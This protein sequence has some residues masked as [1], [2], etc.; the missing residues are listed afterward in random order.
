MF[1]LFNGDFIMAE[2][3]YFYLE[4][5]KELYQ[6]IGERIVIVDNDKLLQ[7][8]PPN[9]KIKRPPRTSLGGLRPDIT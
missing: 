4:S 3:R 6:V 1:K 5:R 8:L 7:S 2:D 9:K